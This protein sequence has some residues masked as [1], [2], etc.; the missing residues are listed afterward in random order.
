M[1]EYDD[2]PLNA[3]IIE[4]IESGTY[5]RER[6][7]LD[8]AYNEERLTIFL[9][10][11]TGS[12]AS[13]PYQ[14]L[15]FFPGSNDIYK[16]S[17]DELRLGSVE[18]VLRSGRAIVY[19]IYKGTYDRKS[20]LRSD[21]QNDSNVYRDHTIAWARDVG[22][23]IDYLET[24]D[25]INTDRLAYLGFS[26]GAAMGPIMTAVEDRFKTAL[27]YVGGMMMQDVQPMADPFNFL[28]RVTIPV[29]MLNGKYDSFF[30]VETA[31]MPFYENLG[32]PEA[33]KKLTITDSNHFVGAYSANQ[34]ISESLDWLDKYL[35]EVE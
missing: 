17:Y 26:W 18:Y 3:E 32:T 34:L 6:I 20:D 23:A 21:V 16:T 25:D 7:E 31:I 22:R 5:V 11:P 28:P 8:A 13:P 33:D 27:F 19:P 14:T 15:L 2:S 1:Y 30:P 9:F 4:T 35:G 29:F 24:R 10:L 12:N